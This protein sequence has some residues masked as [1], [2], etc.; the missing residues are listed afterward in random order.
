MHAALAIDEILSKIIAFTLRR[1]S[2]QDDAASLDA[3]SRHG[4]LQVALVCK[5]FWEPAMSMLWRTLDSLEP[6][7][8][9]VPGLQIHDDSCVLDQD[10]V[11]EDISTLRKY[12]R[13]VR[14][15][16]LKRNITVPTPI[17]AKIRVATGAES[18]LPRLR[19]LYCV[20]EGF[21]HEIS[22]CLSSTVEQLTVILSKDSREGTDREALAAFLS[23]LLSMKD[24]EARLTLLHITGR[25]LEGTMKMVSAFPKLREVGLSLHSSTDPD[26]SNS[27]GVGKSLLPALSQM[28]YLTRLDLDV[29]GSDPFVLPLALPSLQHLRLIG[30]CSVILSALHGS[31]LPS[32]V[33]LNIVV[34][35]QQSGSLDG[36]LSSRISYFNLRILVIRLV[37]SQ[38][39][40]PLRGRDLLAP[41][42]RLRALQVFRLNSRNIRVDLD[43]EDMALIA[44]AWPELF[45]LN[46]F[47]PLPTDCKA[48]NLLGLIPFAEHCP[49]L[50]YLT[51]PVN[52]NCALP[53]QPPVFLHELRH[54][55]LMDSPVTVAP[56]VVARFLHCL[57]PMCAGPRP[58]GHK[59]R[60]PWPRVYW[61][62]GMI[63]TILT[64][65]SRRIKVSLAARTLSGSVDDAVDDHEPSHH[66]SGL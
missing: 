46:I 52:A 24:P 13:H 18:L 15:V 10:L 44:K 21:S 57:F 14:T 63:H 31:S 4:L 28:E 48:P 35:R 43:N 55:D 33:E 26:S 22:L 47:T 30:L 20:K 3:S 61:F 37:G 19:V 56:H 9:L 66:V 1:K 39:D 49:H 45:L 16:A 34:L 23:G 5:A 40:S 7:L 25:L 54:I 27:G 41:L 29:A 62:L 32:L 50:S 2:V 38:T 11:I 64:D 59:Y 42:L 51:V 6:L 60:Y 12:A 17:L 8:L 58:S 53:S 65:N 36:I